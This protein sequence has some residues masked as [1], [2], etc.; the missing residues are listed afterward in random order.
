MRNTVQITTAQL[1]E[2]LRTWA[3]GAQP[4]SLQYVTSPAINKDGK[5]RFGQ[6]T[7]IANIG[8]MIGYKYANSVNNQREREGEITDFMAQKLWKGAGSRISTALATHDAKGT[9][10][11][12]YKK[13][14]TFKSFHFDGVLNFIPSAI[15]RQYFKSSGSPAKY[16]G[17]E[18][19]VYHR[20]IGI[21]NVRK[22]KFK[23]TTYVIVNPK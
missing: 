21:E 19:P 14:Q 22:L 5:E 10:Y 6:V 23:K 17:V 20:E 11:L 13:Q 9:F 4:S 7:K 18:K 16:Q 1:I 15:L 8:C 3:F 2:M 12:T